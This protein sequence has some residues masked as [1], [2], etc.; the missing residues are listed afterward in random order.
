[1]NNDLNELIENTFDAISIMLVFVT[2]LFSIRYPEMKKILEEQLEKDKPIKFKRQ[3]RRIKSELF[4]KWLPVI[5]LNFIVVYTLAP[6]AIKTIISSELALIHFD[7]I[8]TSFVL[9]WYV[10]I[11]F[12]IS[13][14]LIFIKILFRLKRTK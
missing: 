4:Y 8:R 6:L 5:V 13:S 14:L 12:L 7:F 11:A 10:S 9:I 2:V 1:M 3:K